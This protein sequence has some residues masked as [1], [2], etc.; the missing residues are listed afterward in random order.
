[1]VQINFSLVFILAAAAVA[2]VLGLPFGSAT[3]L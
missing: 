2:P 1:M 3:G